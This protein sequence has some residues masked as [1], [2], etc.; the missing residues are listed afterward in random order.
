MLNPDRQVILTGYGGDFAAEWGASARDVFARHGPGLFGLDVFHKRA[1]ADHWGIEGHAGGMRTCGTLGPISGKGCH[2]LIS[3]DQIKDQ[4]QA[5]SAT[6]RDS[7]HQ[8]FL[9]DALSRLEPEGKAIVVLSRRH[10]DDLVGRLLQASDDWQVLRMPA[11][12]D[13]QAGDPLHREQD[14]ALWP[15]RYDAATLL[16][17]KQELEL[18]G[19]SHIWE[20]LYMQNPQ[21]DPSAR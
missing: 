8:W 11:L 4:A 13:D 19:Q 18:A 2:L 12:C 9:A 17:I 21:G 15:E 5:N 20:C 10:P 6:Y 1:R 7:V 3:D 14:A 16:K